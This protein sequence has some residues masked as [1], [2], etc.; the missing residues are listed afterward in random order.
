MTV[1]VYK[2]T[3]A[4]IPSKLS[5][6]NCVIPILDACLVNGYGDKA[7]AGWSKPFSD[8]GI[9]V[10]KG[11]GPNAKY[12]RVSGDEAANNSVRLAGYQTMS[13]ASTGTGMFPD[14][15]GAAYYLMRDLTE[16]ATV[17]NMPWI[18]VATDNF[19]WFCLGVTTSSTYTQ[20][21]GIAGFGEIPSYAAGDTNNTVIVGYQAAYT[22]D[23]SVNGGSGGHNG[24]NIILASD[25]FG[26][27]AGKGGTIFTGF[28]GQSGLGRA[29]TANTPESAYPASI[30]GKLHLAALTVHEDDSGIRGRLPGLF[31]LNVDT[32]LV[33]FKNLDVLTGLAG[34]QFAVI[35]GPN[36]NA[37]C[38]LEISDTW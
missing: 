22:T 21:M 7:P 32:S 19:F 12:L 4:G 27:T 15:T 5:G 26:S 6:L 10:Y 1:H 28:S 9:G 36:T 13:G 35:F 24:A 38:A 31:S 33:P 11:V 3:D 17:A 25:F 8:T 23:M 29:A 14:T 16:G 34:R 30:D 18:L 2:S 37:M 20:N